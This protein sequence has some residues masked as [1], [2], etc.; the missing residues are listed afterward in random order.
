MSDLQ[1]TLKQIT[2]KIKEASTRIDELK[3]GDNETQEQD[4]VI[5]IKDGKPDFDIPSVTP[6]PSV[7]VASLNQKKPGTPV[8]IN[9]EV[10][11]VIEEIIKGL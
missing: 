8:N 6:P 1:S 2:E 7:K 5:E 10:K 3:L 4:I 11:K 9:E